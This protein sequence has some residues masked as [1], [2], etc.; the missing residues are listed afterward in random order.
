MEANILNFLKK[1]TKVERGQKVVLGI[2]G[3]SRS[4]KTTFVRNIKQYIH[5]KSIL[6][7]ILHIDDYIVERKRRYNTG[8]EEW[9][10][11]YSLQWDVE[12]LKENLFKRLKKINE[13]DLL[14]YD[15]SSDTQKSQKVIVPD[16][17][18]IIIEGVFLQRKEWR[19][20]YD[21]MIYLECSREKRFNRESIGTRNNIGKF[22]KRYWKA[23]D[24]Y[25]KIVSP[26]EQ[27]DLV[28]QN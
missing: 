26:M 12:W 8:N 10:E 20:F 7:C 6:I 11:Y 2:D 24:H 5:D 13:L 14:T 18:L 3:L 16:T 1:I 25:M 9:Y 15:Y 28:I 22:E 23:E 4:G 17:C 21:F 19:H 27:A